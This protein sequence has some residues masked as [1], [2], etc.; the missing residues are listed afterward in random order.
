MAICTVLNC[1]NE[2]RGGR[3]TTHEK[4][5]METAPCPE[6]LEKLQNGE[7]WSYSKSH[8]ILMGSDLPPLLENFKIQERVGTGV[9]L[10][11]EA[12]GEKPHT[13]WVPDELARSLGSALGSAG[14]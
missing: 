2:S 13:V 12:A 4:V 10:I 11:L 5:F 8:E 7:Q 3:F 1:E 14:V 6:H 9:T